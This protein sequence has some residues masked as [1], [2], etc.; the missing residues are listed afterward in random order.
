MALEQF[1][2]DA[3]SGECAQFYYGGCKVLI[4]VHIFKYNYSYN[5]MDIGKS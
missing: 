1:Y 5:I 4:I 2:Y 3:D